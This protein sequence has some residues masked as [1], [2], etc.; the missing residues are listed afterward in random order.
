MGS[1]IRK[2]EPVAMHVK[3]IL[4]KYYFK[5]MKFDYCYFKGHTKEN[6]NNLIGYLTNW[7]NRKKL[8]YGEKNSF[9][10]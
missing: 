6:S 9:R 2:L 8:G 7:K 5:G 3:R 10:G 1:V 4:G